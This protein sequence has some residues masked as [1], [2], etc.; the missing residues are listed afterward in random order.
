MSK[1]TFTKGDSVKKVRSTSTGQI[2]ELELAGWV[3]EQKHTPAPKPQL[4]A[5]KKH[6]APESDAI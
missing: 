5:A 4:Q 1:I 6:A 3:P 2:A